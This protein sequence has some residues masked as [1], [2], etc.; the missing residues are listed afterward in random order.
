MTQAFTKKRVALLGLAVL[1]VAGTASC[2][3][4]SDNMPTTFQGPSNGASTENCAQ[5]LQCIDF[6]GPTSL[7]NLISIAK[8]LSIMDYD[9]IDTNTNI[10]DTSKIPFVEGRNSAKF[11]SPEGTVFTMTTD[12]EYRYFKGNGLPNTPM[13][14]FPIP[15]SDPSYRY[16]EVIA[17][18]ENTETG[19]VYNNATEVEIAAFDLTSR[20]PLNPVVTGTY[21]INSLIIGITL[22]GATLDMAL[23]PDRSNNW[24]DANNVLPMDKCYGHPY[25]GIYHYHALAWKCFDQGTSGKQSPVYA[26]AIDGFPITGP[27]GADGRELTNADLDACHGTTSTITMPDGTRKNTYH[28]V[29]NREYPYAIGCFRGKVNY[30]RALGVE[31][32]RETKAPIYIDAPYP[33]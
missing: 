1:T 26:F 8:N 4:G 20:V 17:G 18:G 7:G 25:N 3:D 21:P 28:Y 10:I 27:R 15:S 24:Y 6:S 31:Q 11:Y 5:N 22:S 32:M 14:T 13:G 19:Q 9:W 12:D 23:A 33:Q 2:G 30:F 16:Y 29:F